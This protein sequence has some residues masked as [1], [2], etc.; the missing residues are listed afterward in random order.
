[1]QLPGSGQVANAWN[2]VPGSGDSI[3][4]ANT[5]I[6]DTWYLGFRNTIT[7]GGS[8]TIPVPPNGTV[9][10][11]SNRTVYAIA[12]KGANP[13]VVI[14]G[15]GAYFQGLTQGQG[16]LVLPAIKSPNFITG[17]SGWTIN[18]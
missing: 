7:I 8:N 18:K 1:M 9:T 15:G 2:G 11:T 13:L 3:L 5:D 14:P 17:V 10:L 12:V 6:D 16:Q 4:F